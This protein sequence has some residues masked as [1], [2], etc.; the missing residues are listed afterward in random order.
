MARVDPGR[1][2]VLPKVRTPPTG[3]AT[4]SRYALV[5][6]P[7]YRSPGHRASVRYR[8]TDLRSEYATVVSGRCRGR[9]GSGVPIFARSRARSS[10]WRRGA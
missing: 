4:F 7:V 2:R 1:L 8:G 3:R 5:Q 9:C 10:G 6:V